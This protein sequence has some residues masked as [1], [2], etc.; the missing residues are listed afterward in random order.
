M[1]LGAATALAVALAATAGAQEKLGAEA[2]DAYSQGKTLY[3][4][5]DG[6]AYGAEQYLPGHRVVWAFLGQDC[7]RGT[8]YEEA[9]DICFVYEGETDGPQCWSFYRGSAGLT[10]HFRGDPPDRNLVEVTQSATPLQCE[11]PYVGA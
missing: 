2:F 3:Y 6:E 10:A 8:W 9:G 1:R 4:T 7:Q 5:V 11:G